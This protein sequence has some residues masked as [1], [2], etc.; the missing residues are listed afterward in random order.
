MNRGEFGPQADAIFHIDHVA[1]LGEA[2]NESG[3]QVI[4]LQKGPPFGKS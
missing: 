3:S 4:V 1:V 2:I